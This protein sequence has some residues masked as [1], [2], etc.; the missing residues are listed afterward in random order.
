MTGESSLAKPQRRGFKKPFL[1]AKKKSPPASSHTTVDISARAA[2]ATDAVRRVQ[3]GRR[4]TFFK[5]RVVEPAVKF[6]KSPTGILGGLYELTTALTKKGLDLCHLLPRPKKTSQM[7]QGLLASVS[8]D[9]AVDAEFNAEDERVS[10]REGHKKTPQQYFGR[11]ALRAFIKGG[12][13]LIEAQVLVTSVGSLAIYF[14]P[15]YAALGLATKIMTIAGIPDVFFGAVS[16]WMSYQGIKNQL[17]TGVIEYRVPDAVERQSYFDHLTEPSILK[18]ADLLGRTNGILRLFISKPGNISAFFL[19]FGF[20]AITEFVQRAL[21]ANPDSLP[22]AS[23]RNY[24][25][26]SV[27]NFAYMICCGLG[28]AASHF[29]FVGYLFGTIIASEN[30][31]GN[32]DVNIIF[33]DTTEGMLIR[34]GVAL[35]FTAITTLGAAKAFVLSQASYGK[36][37]NGSEITFMVG[38]F[39]TYLFSNF[40][41]VSNF[42]GNFGI[43]FNVDSFYDN[44]W[45][46]I[47]MGAIEGGIVTAVDAINLDKGLSLLR[48][49]NSRIMNVE[50]SRTSD[51]RFEAKI[52][53][54]SPLA[55]AQ[56]SARSVRLV[57]RETVAEQ[58]AAVRKKQESKFNAFMAAN[59]KVE[60]EDSNRTEENFANASEGSSAAGGSSS[61][62]ASPVGNI[63][64]TAMG[65]LGGVPML[66]VR[67]DGPLLQASSGCLGANETLDSLVKQ[68]RQ[69]GTR[70][71]YANGDIFYGQAD[72]TEE[73]IRELFMAHFYQLNGTDI[74]EVLLGEIFNSIR[75]LSPP[76]NWEKFIYDIN[77]DT[78]FRKGY[79]DV[80]DSREGDGLS[81]NDV[82]EIFQKNPG[83]QKK[84]RDHPD[85]EGEFNDENDRE[86][87]IRLATQPAS[88]C[89][90][91]VTFGNH[92]TGKCF[93][94]AFDHHREVQKAQSQGFLKRAA[95]AVINPIKTGWATLRGWVPH[96]GKRGD[97]NIEQKNHNTL[98]HTFENDSPTLKHI[99][100]VNAHKQEYSETPQFFYLTKNPKGLYVVRAIHPD[101]LM[102]EEVIT[103]TISFNSSSNAT[104]DDIIAIANLVQLSAQ[105]AH[106]I[107][108]VFHHPELSAG[109]RATAIDE[110][111][112]Y[113]VDAKDVPIGSMNMNSYRIMHRVRELV[114][115]VTWKPVKVKQKAHEHFVFANQGGSYRVGDMFT[116]F[117]SQNDK[118]AREML[119]LLWQQLGS[120]AA[121]QQNFYGKLWRY[122]RVTKTNDVNFSGSAFSG[123]ETLPD[124]GMAA[125]RAGAEPLVFGH[126]NYNACVHQL[127]TMM[128]TDETWC[129]HYFTKMSED[130]PQHYATF[131]KFFKDNRFSPALREDHFI[132]ESREFLRDPN[133][134][135]KLTHAVHQEIVQNSDRPDFEIIATGGAPGNKNNRIL[136]SQ[137]IMA[138]V[139]SE[140][141]ATSYTLAESATQMRHTVV[142]E[143]G[144]TVLD[145]VSRSE[146]VVSSVRVE[147]TPGIS[148]KAIE[149]AKAT[150]LIQQLTMIA[151]VGAWSLF[152]PCVMSALLGKSDYNEYEATEGGKAAK[153]GDSAEAKAKLDEQPELSPSAMGMDEEAVLLAPLL[154][155]GNA[156]PSV[157]EAEAVPT[158]T[159][160]EKAARKLEEKKQKKRCV[161]ARDR[162]KKERDPQF[163]KQALSFWA[164]VQAQGGKAQQN[165]QQVRKNTADWINLS[166]NTFLHPLLTV[167]EEAPASNYYNIANQIAAFLGVWIEVLEISS[168]HTLTFKQKEERL[169]EAYAK[170]GV[171]YT[172]E[173]LIDIADI[174]SSASLA[175]KAREARTYDSDILRIYLLNVAHEVVKASFI[176]LDQAIAKEVIAY[177][178]KDGLPPEFIIAQLIMV[179]TEENEFVNNLLLALAG[180]IVKDSCTNG[181]NNK[182]A[183]VDPIGEELEILKVK[184]NLIKYFTQEYM[185]GAATET[186]ILFGNHLH[187]T[188]MESYRKHGPLDCGFRDKIS[189]IYAS[190]E[191]TNSKPLV[192][193][194][195]PPE[196]LVASM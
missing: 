1:G 146:G 78:F 71:Y 61:A 149:N 67:G 46:A 143:N 176:S 166:K 27:K 65:A 16:G 109:K 153:M 159:I 42:F 179:F 135:D 104:E 32:E 189:A 86:N 95:N 116:H 26:E 107:Q 174:E 91:V 39:I 14:V 105:T 102:G 123:L 168:S 10:T 134:V 93:S 5:R 188:A 119:N 124:E 74:Q 156:K 130:Q 98:K 92:D 133:S 147:H 31:N 145:A 18:L 22:G 59:P 142:L 114:G 191:N 125:I 132:A 194:E 196:V 172:P 77:N 82:Q 15:T 69:K 192:L 8:A 118:A 165:I 12:L 113:G 170:V 29:S 161:E 178:L 73:R 84:L 54:D 50:V 157:A 34:L 45:L 21:V 83:L 79:L 62:P 87:F 162:A 187:A 154:S 88:A 106:H 85:Y 164:S 24:S 186:C 36:K 52:N 72:F 117:V 60:E 40:F 51:M 152:V 180:K 131:I 6:L 13:A 155:S 175:E 173:E 185:G 30:P 160:Q 195:L 89:I 38:E 110:T 137:M 57:T 48:Q 144:T 64:S 138:V 148:A 4:K 2:E 58:I 81:L 181:P 20:N 49:A 177:T 28:I 193:P 122:F 150:Q 108:F 25:A 112:K 101:R 136:P 63:I 167:G 103:D 23:A 7:Q 44:R 141:N 115:E 139:G 99:P 80:F 120:K 97:N 66:T 183:T 53:Y 3:L 100:H 55:I 19:A 96:L 33:S 76:D 75:R 158:E 35:G 70:I 127:V 41:L 169:V 47:T 128:F 111:H 129:K 184:G 140:A 126:K 56:L 171:E 94:N 90:I 11:K 163:L 182:L 190:P 43:G 121:E 37:R 68:M 17:P 151:R 9:N